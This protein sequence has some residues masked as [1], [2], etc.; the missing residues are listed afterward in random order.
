[1][2]GYTHHCRAQHAPVKHISRLK[3]LQN[4]AVCVVRCFSAIQRLM[5]VRIK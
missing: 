5:Q 2:H 1:M 4:G 3:Y